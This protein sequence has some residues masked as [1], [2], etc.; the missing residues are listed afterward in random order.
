MGGQSRQTYGIA[1]GRNGRASIRCQS[2]K[3]S[4]T[5]APQDDHRS[6]AACRGFAIAG[7]DRTWP[8]G[9][10]GQRAVARPAGLPKTRPSSRWT[11]LLRIVFAARLSSAP[12]RRQVPPDRSPISSLAQAE[13]CADRA[14]SQH[15]AC[16]P[17]FETWAANVIL[18]PLWCSCPMMPPSPAKGSQGQIGIK[19]L[20]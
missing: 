14:L 13:P 4:A 16:N 18:A 1:P 6:S 12:V 15:E 8:E 7:P 3:A 11:A 17:P 9:Q 2:G 5:R 10:D 20:G 19:H